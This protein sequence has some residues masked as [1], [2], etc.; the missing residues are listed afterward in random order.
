[1]E[2][3]KLPE[4]ELLRVEGA[5]FYFNCEY[6]GKELY[7]LRSTLRKNASSHVFCCGE[8]KIQGV[9]VVRPT[10]SDEDLSYIVGFLQGDGYFVNRGD[11][12]A[13]T[14]GFELGYKDIEL[15]N[16]IYSLLSKDFKCRKWERTRNTNFKKEV[17]SC[18][19][20][21]TNRQFINFMRPLLPSGKK[22]HKVKPP[23]KEGWFISK[24]Y[25][26]G[27]YDADGSLGCNNKGSLFISLCSNSEAIKD[28]VTSEISKVIEFDMSINRNKRDK[29][30]NITL[31]NERARDFASYLYKDSNIFLDRKYN[32]WLKMPLWVRT[33]AKHKLRKM[34]T[35]SEIAILLD[36]KLTI[37][38]IFERIDREPA[39]IRAKLKKLLEV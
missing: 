1:M 4:A 26:R 31:H 19:F 8:C 13:G 35:E 14:I 5:R 39:A 34:W 25:L 28:F 33:Q 9:N 32:K 11:G 23:V 37:E 20:E 36:Y 27:L 3:L 29:V 10:I 6:C 17:K 21:T 7:R 22:S 16:K 24:D 12:G 38:E 15:R 18:I 2:D 30:Y